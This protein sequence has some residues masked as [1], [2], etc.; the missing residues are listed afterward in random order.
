M[1]HCHSNA[2]D[3]MTYFQ[4]CINVFLLLLFTYKACN[5]LLPF[6]ESGGIKF[7]KDIHGRSLILS[8]FVIN[9]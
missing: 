9:F 8:L 7:G 6:S 1:L 4:F 5:F 2:V 3:Y